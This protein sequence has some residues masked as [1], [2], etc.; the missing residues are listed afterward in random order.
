MTS[1]QY[2]SLLEELARVSGLGDS[3][4]LLEHGRLKIG[5]INAVLEHDPKYDEHLLQVRMLLGGFPE[6]QQA[7]VTKA[8]LEANY[9]SG[10]GGECVFSLFPE[11]DDVVLTMKMRLNAGPTAQELWQELSDIA[12][13]GGQMWETIVASM[14]TTQDVFGSDAAAFARV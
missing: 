2:R 4:S 5:D 11:S 14:R 7:V 9:I 13:H 3:S 8:L 12:R 1:E 6:Q 10:Y